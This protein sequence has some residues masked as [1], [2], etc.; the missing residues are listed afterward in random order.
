[1]INYIGMYIYTGE[2]MKV[3]ILTPSIY[4]YQKRYSGRIFA[5]GDLVRVLV[6]LL[7]KRGHE[8]W[9]FTAPEEKIPEAVRFVPGN[10][11]LLDGDLKMRVLQDV[12]PEIITRVSLFGTKMYYE[13]DLVTRAYTIAQ[14]ENIAVMHHF[15]SFGFLAH[16]FEEMTGLPTVYTLHDP[17]PTA[18][19]L[20]RWLFDRFPNHRF[21]SISD[22]QRGSFSD[23]FIDTVFN[24]ID[25]LTYSFDAVGG[26]GYI[27]VGRMVPEK[28]IHTAI[29]VAQQLGIP[30]KVASWINDNVRQSK[31]Y[32]QKIAPNLG[33]A[34]EMS[35]LLEGQDKIRFFQKAKALLFPIEWEEPF[36]MVMIEAMACGT[37]V[38]A[39]NRGSVP[40][41]VKDGVTGF[42]VEPERGIEGLV[43]AVKRIG[44]IDRAACRRHVEENFTIE[45]MVDGYERVYRK[46]ASKGETLR[47]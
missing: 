7:A 34:V 30:L 18:N 42:I 26:E 11:E 33:R 15:H 8:V 38:I 31:Y 46:V 41:I 28:G 5:P 14:K 25:T 6:A 32:Q 12:T 9:W 24:G 40:E 20:E 13:M 27:A 4:M 29:S 2:H 21:L 47:G 43:E 10:L 16:F 17:I 1:M 22:A 23:H 35:D 37:P 19:M 36:G 45:K 44:E 39:Y 3:G